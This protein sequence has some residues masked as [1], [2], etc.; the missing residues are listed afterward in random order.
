MN[1]QGIE[2]QN[3]VI[4]FD[5]SWFLAKN[6]DFEDPYSLLGKKYIFTNMYISQGLWYG[7]T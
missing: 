4:S 2:K 1:C 6:L 7:L 5:Y 3:F